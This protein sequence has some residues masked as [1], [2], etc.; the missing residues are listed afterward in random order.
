MRNY[1][2]TNKKSF[3]L[4]EQGGRTGQAWHSALAFLQVVNTCALSLY[5]LLLLLLLLRLII[6]IQCQ[7]SPENAPSDCAFSIT[8]VWAVESQPGNAAEISSFSAFSKKIFGELNSIRR[9]HSLLKAGIKTS[10]CLNSTDS[11]K[12]QLKYKDLG[13][14]ATKCKQKILCCQ[15]FIHGRLPNLITL[16]TMSTVGNWG[17]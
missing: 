17:D 15:M 12:P 7:F 6:S 3:I 1:C 4:Q 13:G 8:D 16:A 2:D 9:I 5:L 11:I 14:R 10:D